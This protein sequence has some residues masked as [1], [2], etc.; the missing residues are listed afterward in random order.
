MVPALRA[1]VDSET[2]LVEIGTLGEWIDEDEAYCEAAQKA[3][4]KI[5]AS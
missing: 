4:A 3:L 5:E 1:I 2:R